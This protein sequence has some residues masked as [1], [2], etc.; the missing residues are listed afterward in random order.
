MKRLILFLAVA[1]FACSPAFGAYT[2]YA[3]PFNYYSSGCYSQSHRRNDAR[4]HA[5][6][7]L[8]H[9]RECHRYNRQ[10]RDRADDLYQR[11]QLR[12]S[13]A[14]DCWQDLRNWNK[15]CKEAI[16][17]QESLLFL[18][19][20]RISVRIWELGKTTELRELDCI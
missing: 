4:W 14:G 3:S 18:I 8:R 9:Q 1:A 12:G 19:A 20:G 16:F 17:E 2:W 5:I 7:H 13:V 15:I 6:V 11:D 10:R